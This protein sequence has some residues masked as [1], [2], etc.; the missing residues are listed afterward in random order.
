MTRKEADN[1]LEYLETS[2]EAAKRGL[3]R[4]KRR[5]VTKPGEITAKDCW[6]KIALELNPDVLEFFDSNS[7]KINQVLRHEMEKIKMRE[8]L[9]AD[10][11]FVNR[12]REKLAA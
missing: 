3:R 10:V 1:K 11:E 5:H 6:A 4:I 7:E 8:E 12:L 9:L 2:K